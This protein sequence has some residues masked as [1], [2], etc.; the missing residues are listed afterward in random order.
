VLLAL[1]LIAMDRSTDVKINST[2]KKS[3]NSDPLGDAYS[4]TKENPQE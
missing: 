1:D 4:V 3:Y 2:G